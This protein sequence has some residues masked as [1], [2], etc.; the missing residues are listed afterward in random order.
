[1]GHGIFLMEQGNAGAGPYLVKAF[2]A[3]RNLSG[4]RNFLMLAESRDTYLKPSV[5]LLNALSESGLE[6]PG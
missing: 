1:M 3:L 6:N 4:F 2:L 5:N